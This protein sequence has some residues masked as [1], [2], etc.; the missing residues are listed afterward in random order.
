MHCPKCK[1]SLS[2]WDLGKRFECP[3]CRAQLQSTGWGAV[4][5]VNIALFVVAGGLMAALLAS[6]SAVGVIV[7]LAVLAAWV[8]LEFACMRTFLEISFSEEQPMSPKG[9]DGAI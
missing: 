7:G 6:E 4:T 3:R 2:V 8:W 9:T 1:Q 5:A